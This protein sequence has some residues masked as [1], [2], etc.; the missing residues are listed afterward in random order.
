VFSVRFDLWFYRHVKAPSVVVAALA[1]ELAISTKYTAILVF[2]MLALLAVCEILR[3][4]NTADGAQSEAKGKRAVR[5][6]GALVLIT[7]ISVSVLWSFYGFRCEP[8]ANHLAMSLRYAQFVKSLSRPNDVWLLPTVGRF[9]LLR[10]AHGDEHGSRETWEIPGKLWCTD[11]RAH[12]GYRF[13]WPRPVAARVPPVLLAAVVAVKRESGGE[14][15]LHGKE[16]IHARVENMVLV[17]QTLE[18]FVPCVQRVGNLR[19][20]KNLRQRPARTA[21]GNRVAPPQESSQNKRFGRSLRLWKSRRKGPSVTL[22][23]A[24]N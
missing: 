1:T 8:R 2:P 21:R 10:D 18:N 15:G 20:L 24:S 17:I 9:H 5:L 4:D 7:V 3:R 16:I 6:A 11:L 22:Q 13:L 23:R 12:H 19:I 14:K